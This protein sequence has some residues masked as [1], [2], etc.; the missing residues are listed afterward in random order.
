[1]ASKYEIAE[2]VIR[3]LPYEERSALAFGFPIPET[4]EFVS[5]FVNESKDEESTTDVNG[6]W[7]SLNQNSM[8]DFDGGFDFA[9][10]DFDNFLTKKARERNKKKR[11]LKKDNRDSGMSRKDAR[12]SAREQ[13]LKEIPRDSLKTIAKNT[14]KKV[15][16]AIKVGALVVP[17]ASF[18]SLMMINFRGFAWKFNEVMTNP[19]YS[20]KLA[21]LKEKWNKL[22][23]NWNNNKFQN[24]I[25][26]GKGKKPFFCGK[27]CKQKLADGNIKRAFDGNV[28]FYQFGGVDDV[29]VGVW[30]GLG[31]SVIGALGGIATSVITN[32]GKESEIRAS[33]DIAEKELATLSES[34]KRRIALAEK[35]LV[36]EGDPIR[37][38]QNNPNLT[39]QQKS[40]AIAQVQEATEKTNTSNLKKYAIIGGLA[41]VGILVLLKVVKSK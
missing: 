15:G 19:S 27:K 5:N 18:L 1:M 41:L 14:I 25:N 3:G 39:A 12:K 35:K 4:S 37:Q 6:D 13:A 24:A 9:D 2:E 33:K 16:R 21:Q 30:I 40:E 38:I 26:R 31:A 17:R 8:M 32:K 22:G 23:G 28:E 36:S 10:D 29:A 7:S 20:K 11:E 34:E